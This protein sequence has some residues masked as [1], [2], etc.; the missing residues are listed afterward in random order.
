M[1]PS[2]HLVMPNASDPC[3]DICCFTTGPG[4]DLRTYLEGL[5]MADNVKEYVEQN[6][7]GQG[8][9]TKL[10]KQWNFYCKIV[11]AA[12]EPAAAK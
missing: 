3:F 4:G 2:Y 5:S 10:H 12:V 7:F 1:E 8:A 6:P 11:A 9:I